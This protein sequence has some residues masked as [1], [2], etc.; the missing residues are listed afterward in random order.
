MLRNLRYTGRWAFGRK[1]NVWSSKLDYTK[2]EDQPDTEVTA[3]HSEELRIVSDELFFAVQARFAKNCH[4]ARGPK[5]HGRPAQ[6]WDLVTECFICSLC[7]EHKDARYYHY[8]PGN[9][10]MVCRHR[11]LCPTMTTV[12]RKEAVEAVLDKLCELID[13]DAELVAK[14][15]AEAQQLDATPDGELKNKAVSLRGRIASQAN[16]INDLFE[17]VGAGTDAD[18]AETKA[19]IRTAQARRS[20]LQSELACI[21]EQL[22]Q[23]HRPIAPED[24]RTILSD[25]R[26]LLVDAGAGRL[27]EDVVYRAAHTFKL[28]VGGRILVCVEPRP[29]R[30]RTVVRGRFTPRLLAAVSE[31]LSSPATATADIPAEVVVWL[32][33]PP[34][35]DELA[36]RVHELVDGQGLSYGEAADELC[37]D[38]HGRMSAVRISL[39]YTRYYEIVQQ[40]RP[41]HGYNHDR[42]RKSP[43]R[44]K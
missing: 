28:L 12:N 6:I 30:K 36:Y 27:G 3:I 17:V 15:I 1:R 13:K 24:A 42:P 19:Q 11:E 35:C 10:G 8:G 39:L 38:G 29:G 33:K 40:P 18:R 43:Q 25:F 9:K 32:R 31:Q 23:R 14:V 44:G 37:R 41:R 21:E 5:G 4:G 26:R 22:E 7:S 20:E 34:K 16:K 2:Q